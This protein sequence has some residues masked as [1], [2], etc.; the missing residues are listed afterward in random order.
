MTNSVSDVEDTGKLSIPTDIGV[1]IH[2]NKKEE[3]D[4]DK[5]KSRF[6]KFLEEQR[7][8]YQFKSF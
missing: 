8:S 1:L 4:K 6:D 7:K 2:V 5:R 3:S